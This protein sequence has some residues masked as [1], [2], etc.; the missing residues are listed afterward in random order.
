MTYRLPPHV[1]HRLLQGEAILLDTRT[2]A[3]LGLNRSAAV[4]WEVLAAGGS[5]DEAITALID[6]FDVSTETATRD[7]DRLAADLVRR[8]LLE[9][10]DA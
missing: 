6:R 10:I 7:V 3:Y 4:A 2:D 1:H 8:G 9:T 5:H